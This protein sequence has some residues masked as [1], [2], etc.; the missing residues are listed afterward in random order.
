MRRPGREVH[1]RLFDPGRILVNN[2]IG[3]WE[4]AAQI[5]LDRIGNPVRFQQGQPAI[6]LNVQLDERG[7]P[8]DPGL[9]VVD[10]GDLLVALS[11]RADAGAL[12]IG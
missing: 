12:F 1:P 3:M 11:D 4:S 7:R 10:G 2:Y 5:G 8:S 6:H 9:D